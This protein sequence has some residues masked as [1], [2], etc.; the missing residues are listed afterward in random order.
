MGRVDDPYTFEHSGN[1]NFA[2]IPE[3]EYPDIYNFLVNT[4]SPYTK[5]ELKAYKSLDGYKYL[6]AEWVG[7]VSL[8][9]VDSDTA[10][11]MAK[12][13]HSQSVSKAALC[14]W[15]GAKKSGT[16]L[17]AHCTCMAGLGEACS[18]IAALL[19][20]AEAHVRLRRDTS[21]TS[22]PCEWLSPTLKSVNYKPISEI[23]FTNPK[24]KRRRLECATASKAPVPAA[25]I[26]P[27][28]KSDLS[29]LYE[30]L[31]DAG[32][33]ALLSI[34]PKY[35]DTY[36]QNGRN[37]PLVF[38]DLYQED[39]LEL[40][41]S[42]LVA[43]GEEMFASLTITDEDVKVIELETRKQ[44]Q[45]KKWFQHRSG[46]ITASKSKAAVSTSITKP[47]LSLIKQICYPESCKFSTQ[48]TR[49]G[50]SHEK[51]A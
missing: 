10:V 51:D 3:I 2:M 7:D 6:I 32:K 24:T 34:V 15:I 20:A 23:D 33:P 30:A 39:L 38:T 43:K 49:W 13:R 36:A 47:S 17:C 44:A 45:C 50:I 46:R 26:P 42:E 41:Y 27:P 4:P 21:C 40:T 8:H 1:T 16:I 25:T 18:H 31:A 14:P 22:R 12:V 9:T 35:C 29:I 28:A 19:F 48:A 37:L 5:E 11:I